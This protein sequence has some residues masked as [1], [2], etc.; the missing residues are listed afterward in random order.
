MMTR[1][2]DALLVA[3]EATALAPGGHALGADPV[4]GG[5]RFGVWA[6]RAR[7][8]EVVIEGE[9]EHA[10]PLR[11]GTSG[12]HSAVVPGAAAGARYRYRLDGTD[13]VSR[14]RCRA[15]S[16]TDRTARRWS[17]IR[18]RIAWRTRR[19]AGVELPGQVFYELHVGTFTRRGHVRAPP[20]ASCRELRELGITLLE[21]MPV[22]E[23]PGR[24]NWGYDGVDLFAP[25][26]VY[27]D[28]RRP[29]A[30][31]RRG[32]RASASA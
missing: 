14:I 28:A 11:A 16:P 21:L 6:P 9:P 15:S 26:T 7:A 32:A 20:R 5:V 10:H 31:R 30:L 8:V 12:Y 22:A 1:L 23:F 13:D 19:G 24:F 27:G 17:S 25:H 29:P 18:R 3:A 4:P 2:D